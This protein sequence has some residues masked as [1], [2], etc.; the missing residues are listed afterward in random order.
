LLPAEFARR[1]EE[2]QRTLWFI[3]AGV[4][5][6]RTAAHDVVQEAAAIAM[7]KLNEFDSSTNFTAWMGQIVR[8]VAL[9]E[10]RSRQRRRTTTS[11][12]PAY[13]IGSRMAHAEP[14]LDE[15]VQAGLMSLDDPARTCL[16]LRIVHGMSYSEI[17]Q[18]LNIPEGTAMSHVHRSRLALRERL[19]GREDELR[20]AGAGG[21][22]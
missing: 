16:L 13:Q 19:R 21:R 20:H 17:S 1:F 9:N 5:G 3:A 15:H 4:L 18:A 12:E 22:A 6:D 14:G 10:A 2:S 7:T 8:F 11:P